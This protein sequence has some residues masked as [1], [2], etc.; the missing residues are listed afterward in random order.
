MLRDTS[1]SK[2][3]PVCFYVVVIYFPRPFISSYARRYQ[4][5]YPIRKFLGFLYGVVEW[6]QTMM[7]KSR[8]LS[9]IAG[10]SL[11]LDRAWIVVCCCSA[12]YCVD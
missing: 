12:A 9:I 2:L 6:T 4:N 1:E 8:L 3:M 7:G 5:V 11:R 10:Q